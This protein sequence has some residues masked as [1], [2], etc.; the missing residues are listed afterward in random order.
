MVTDGA[1]R[2]HRS[3]SLWAAFRNLDADAPTD[4]TRRY[5]ALCTHYGMT[6]SR[7]NRGVAH[8]NGP[9][10][11]AHLANSGYASTWLETTLARFFTCRLQFK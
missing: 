10:E 5:E 2:E 1:P 7:N 9:I 8:D 6:P 4:L 3:D 11:S